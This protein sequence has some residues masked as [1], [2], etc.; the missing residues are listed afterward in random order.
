MR[1]FNKKDIEKMSNQEIVR[2]IGEEKAGCA[3]YLPSSLKIKHVKNLTKLEEVLE[4][5]SK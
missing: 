1:I 4:K 2:R 3:M 5:R